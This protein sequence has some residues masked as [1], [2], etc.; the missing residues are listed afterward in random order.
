MGLQG[1]KVSPNK[2]GQWGKE[3]YCQPRACISQ[4]LRECHSRY[5]RYGLDE[6][7]LSRA[8]GADDD[9]DGKVEVEVEPICLLARRAGCVGGDCSE[10]RRGAMLTRCRGGY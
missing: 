1:N 4:C 8:L 10:T 3:E 7:R 5:S 9:D 6:R 2:G